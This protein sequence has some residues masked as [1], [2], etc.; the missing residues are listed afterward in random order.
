MANVVN[1]TLFMD[2]PSHATLHCFISSD[3]S[4]GELTDFVLLDPVIDL[5][6]A[7]QPRQD[8]TLKRIWH[9]A[10]GCSVTLAFNS[11][12]PWPFWVMSPDGGGNDLDWR[13]V[14]GITDRS[15]M[16][17]FADVNNPG[18]ETNI[19]QAGAVDPLT[20]GADSDGKLLMSTN[21]FTSVGDS[22]SFVLWLEKRNRSNPQPI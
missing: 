9:E 3:G 14:G 17:L 8:L 22:A 13:F 11:L 5:V 7:M 16:P 18:F 6:P 10:S 2:G 1:R 20:G 15:S 4:S 12:T 21:G 19:P